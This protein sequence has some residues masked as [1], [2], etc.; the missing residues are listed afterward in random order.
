MRHTIVMMG[1]AGKVRDVFSFSPPL[2]FLTLAMPTVW[3][4]WPGKKKALV[5]L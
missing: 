5:G 3:A 4:P 2:S 1:W